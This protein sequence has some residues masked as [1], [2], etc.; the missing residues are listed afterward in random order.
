MDFGAY[1][2]RGRGPCDS[3]VLASWASI[4]LIGGAC[5]DEFPVQSFLSDRIFK[6]ESAI[7]PK[8]PAG[9]AFTPGVGLDIRQIE[10][11]FRPYAN[12]RWPS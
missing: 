5:R 8:A 1:G 4:H 6:S 7:A 9:R 10:F 2:H 3:A 11:R 12:P